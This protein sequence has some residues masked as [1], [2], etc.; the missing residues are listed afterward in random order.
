[1]YKMAKGKILILRECKIVD[2]SATDSY[3][4]FPTKILAW[5]YGAR[6]GIRIFGPGTRLNA[7]VQKE[8]I[9]KY[10]FRYCIPRLQKK[11]SDRRFMMQWD[12]A[13]AHASQ[14]TQDYIKQKYTRTGSGFIEKGQWPP[15]SCDLTLM[16]FAFFS[17]FKTRVYVHRISHIQR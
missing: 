12:N 1:M 9:L 7:E 4:L 13:P 3:K 11:F 17:S 2:L 16:D 8:Q 10:L 15:Y 6:V 14:N 5:V